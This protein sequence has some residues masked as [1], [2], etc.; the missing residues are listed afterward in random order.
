MAGAAA[1]A[2]S[3]AA[4]RHDALQA[5]LPDRP[6]FRDRQLLA[7]LLSAEYAPQNVYQTQEI[8]A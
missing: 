4:A 8:A 2:H 6:R 7:E 5:Q 1:T 3:V